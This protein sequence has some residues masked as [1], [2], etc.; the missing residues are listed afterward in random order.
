MNNYFENKINYNQISFYLTDKPTIDER[1]I[2]P[3]HEILFFIDGNAELLS[4]NGHHSLKESSIIIIPEETYHFF[5]F[6]KTQRFAR[7][8]ISFPKNTLE[9]TPLQEIMSDLKIVENFSGEIKYIFDKLCDIIKS[10]NKNAAFYA[11]STFLMLIAELDM[12]D[13][14][15][16][17]EISQKNNLIAPITEYISQNL[18]AELDIKSLAEIMHISPSG[19]THLFKKEFGIPIH[20]FIIQKRLIYAKKLIN[21][22]EQPS[23]IYADVGFKDYSSFYKAYVNYFGH[24]PSRDKAKNAHL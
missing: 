15:A 20:K 6:K 13:L 12:F 2:H 17:R 14:A 19:I 23:K 21:K 18:S 22:G 3:Y 4:T 11:Y 16:D 24:A 5:I 1:Q 8:K 10:N 9:D 7:L